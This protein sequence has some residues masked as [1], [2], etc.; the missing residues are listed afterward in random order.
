MLRSP[1]LCAISEGARS[2][3]LSLTGEQRGDCGAAVPATGLSRL[4]RAEEPPGRAVGPGSRILSVVVA[5]QTP[6][7]QVTTWLRSQRQE[8]REWAFE[9][10]RHMSDQGIDS[11]FGK[12]D[13]PEGAIRAMRDSL[14][15]PSNRL[16]FAA[17]ATTSGDRYYVRVRWPEGN[18]DVRDCLAR[19]LSGALISSRT[20]A[21][22]Q[23][24]MASIKSRLV[25]WYDKGCAEDIASA[26]RRCGGTAVYEGMGRRR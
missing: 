3:R 10:I 23:Q 20:L 14:H 22:E 6:S 13:L 18:G 11:L 4:F 2:A 19:V 16:R 9:A 8:S 25:Y 1:P 21:Q 7:W 5:P 17:T 24:L 26:V 15:V 12:G